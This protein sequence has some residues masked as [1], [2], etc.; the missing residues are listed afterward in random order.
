MNNPT[1]D[2]PWEEE[3]GA[4]TVRHVD[5]DMVSFLYRSGGFSPLECGLGIVYKLQA[6]LSL[7]HEK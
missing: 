7:L 4:E 1:G 6:V 2:T 3:P 5:G